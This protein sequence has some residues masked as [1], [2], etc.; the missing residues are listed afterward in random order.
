MTGI[1]L[2]A[3]PGLEL[4][5]GRGLA[6]NNVYDEDYDQVLTSLLLSYR[7]VVND[8]KDRARGLCGE[9]ATSPAEAG[10]GP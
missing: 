7:R 4:S 2:G 5:T 10:R 9:C 3:S 6:V 8:M 1:F